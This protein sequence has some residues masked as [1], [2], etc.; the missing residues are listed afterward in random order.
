LIRASPPRRRP[1]ND[2]LLDHGGVFY[3]PATLQ[4]F[5]E[6]FEGDYFFADFCSGWTRRRS[7]EPPPEGANI[8]TFASGIERPVDLEVS[9]EGELYY[10][11]RGNSSTTGSVG[12]ILYS[13]NP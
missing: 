10:L 13:G 9:K 1:Y 8:S 4:Y 2:G 11:S 7:V 5:A 12:K 6:E 3:N